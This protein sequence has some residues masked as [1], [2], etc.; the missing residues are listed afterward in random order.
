MSFKPILNLRA[1]TI[2]KAFLLNAIVLS[3]IAAGSIELRRYLDIRKE[4]KGLTRLQ[5]VIITISGTFIIGVAV[6]ILARI[7]FGFGE[8]LMATP[9]FST[10][11]I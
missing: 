3:I 11:L 6:Y 1:T 4:T 10:K 8:G 7:S 2:A 5:K 9:P